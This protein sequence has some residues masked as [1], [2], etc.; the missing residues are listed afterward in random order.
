MGVKSVCRFIFRRLFEAAIVIGLILLLPN[1]P[2][3][4]NFSNSIRLP[5]TKPLEGKLALNEK[6]NGVEIWHEGDL[7]GPEA[8]A[9]FNGELYTSIVGGDIVKLVGND[10]KPVAKTG[11]PC[12]SLHEE[13]VCGRPLGIRFN[14]NG[15]LFV[16]DAYYGIMKVN[17]KTGHKEV[18][19]SPDQD[20][21]GRRV[22]LF[23]S[24]ALAENGD[25]Y[26]TDSSEFSLEDGIFSLLADPSGRLIHYDAKSKTNR[27]LIDNIHFA[28]GV[29]LSD[30]EEFVIVAET[31]GNRIFRYY[32]KGPK[33]GTRDVFIDGL[34]G[35]P[36]NLK[37][38]GQGGVLI[39]LIKPVDSEN[40]SP[41]HILLPF[42]L[43]RKFVARVLGIFELG[44]ETL[45]KFYPSEFAQKAVHKIGHFTTLPDIFEPSRT[46][47]I[48]ATK[49]GDIIE[50]LSSTNKR[51][52]NFC[53]AHFFNNYLYLASP[54]NDFIG[55]IPLSE[56]GWEH[57]SPERVKRE[58]PVIQPKTET[59]STTTKPT[60]TAQSVKQQQAPP[61][62]QQTTSA[63]AR[64]TTPTPT[65]QPPSRQNTPT[66]TKQPPPPPPHQPPPPKQGM[67][68]PSQENSSPA[69]KQTAPPEK[70]ASTK[71]APS[72]KHA[73]PETP[74]K[75]DSP[76]KQNPPPKQASA[77]QKTSP[78]KQAPPQQ[79]TPPPKQAP[80]QQQT[81]PPKQ[82][83]PQQQTPPKQATPQQQSPTP[84]Q[85][86]PQQQ[87]P[88]SK[89][90][91]PQNSPK[92][93]PPQNSPNKVPPQQQTPPKN[94]PPQQQI[95]P[96]KATPQQQTPPPRQAS[97][98][99][100]A[101]PLK[102]AP[103]PPQ[104]ST[105]KMQTT[106]QAP[107]SKQSAPAKESPKSRNR[108]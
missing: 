98:Q 100:Q 22:K 10:I 105:P 87:T 71:Q 42:P 41:A 29:L 50:N 84:K 11:K 97:P 90:T 72:P 23:N 26:W 17:V 38:D 82:A 5:P 83:P 37:S 57:L 49:S 59:V 27:V 1:L 102:Q 60:M 54:F 32:L 66:P 15:D 81:P 65:K 99:Q 16:A 91:P 44:F 69:T 12:K 53:E 108:R 33:K 107:S 46:M 75:Q 73:S 39:T 51:L 34:P 8:F 67:K 68:Q 106:T 62:K 55:R 80:P 52:K 92:Q 76:Q 21:G 43:I 3:Y 9:D 89:Q 20:I 7:L 48:R 88:L 103:P 93:T 36:D 40:P 63:P 45:N 18:I 13:S 58:V 64:Q 70:L 6:L 74:P 77:Q 101:P 19:I 56:I 86:P 35:L 4:S 95:P 94:A 24:I 96:K 30:D 31:V 85:A 79:Q 2:P 104:Q 61:S 25:I 47:V 28:N 78:P 14:K